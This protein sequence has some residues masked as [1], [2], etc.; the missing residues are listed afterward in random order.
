MSPRAT[1]IEKLRSAWD[2]LRTA[3]F[4]LAAALA[5][6]VLLLVASACSSAG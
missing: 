3:G 2:R 1:R 5:V 4:P 6:S